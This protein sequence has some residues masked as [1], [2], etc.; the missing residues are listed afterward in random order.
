MGIRMSMDTATRTTM[1]IMTTRTTTMRGTI[2]RGMTT[3]ATITA[4][5][6]VTR[7]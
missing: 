3:P 4:L 5:H 1:T 7:P 2:M 6:P